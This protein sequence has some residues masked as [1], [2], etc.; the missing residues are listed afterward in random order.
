MKN[1]ESIIIVLL[2]INGAVNK[3]F[4]SIMSKKNVNTTIKTLTIK[5]KKLKF[6]GETLEISHKL[7]PKEMEEVIIIVTPYP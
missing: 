4:L 5:G 3:T 6:N 2:I 1:P 7:R